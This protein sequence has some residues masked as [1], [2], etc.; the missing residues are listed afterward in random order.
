MVATNA[1]GMG[2]DKSDVRFVIHYNMPKNM[3][4]YYQEAGRAG[5]DGEPSECILYYEPMDVRTNRFFIEN[6]EENEELDSF[7]RKIVKER[8][9]ERL[10]QMTFYCF[11]SECLRHYILRYFGENKSNYCGNCLNCLTQ[12][13]EMDFTREA[14]A[15]INCVGANRINYGIM[16]VIDILRGAKNQKILSRGLDKNPE[17]GTLAA[18]SVTRLR[19]I[20]WEMVYRGYLEMTG[21][22][23][24]VICT[25]ASAMDFIKNKN[26]LVMK[27]AKEREDS[28]SKETKRSRQK[29]AGAAAVLSERDLD[30]FEKLR[31]V[32]REIAAEEKVPPYIIFSDKTLTLMSAVRPKNA[33]EMLKISG[34]GEFKMEKYGDRFLRV[35]KEA[36]DKR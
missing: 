2:I 5:R 14:R 17:Y 35:L 21:D 6:S 32:R 27:L 26:T 24:P 11:T 25:T 34:V 36:E 18:V 23:Y 29:K 15:V 22:E 10:K 13:E 16:I 3:E 8:D 4:S 31:K 30:T 19:H 1:F 12:F 20:L 33:R 9:E 7:A 28:S